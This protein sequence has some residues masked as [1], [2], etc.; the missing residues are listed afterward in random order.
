MNVQGVD[1]GAAANVEPVCAMPDGFLGSVPREVAPF[2][3]YATQRVTGP[4]GSGVQLGVRHLHYSDRN[5]AVAE[6][7]GRDAWFQ[8]V[9]L[10]LSSEAGGTPFAWI[11]RGWVVDG[12]SEP[13]WT[14]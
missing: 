13:I 14:W 6:P 10:P 8:H 5:R 2:E 1:S 3:F 7:L 11:A 4:D 12:T 9:S